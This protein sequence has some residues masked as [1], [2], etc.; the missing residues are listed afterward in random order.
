MINYLNLNLEQFDALGKKYTVL[1]CNII[2]KVF[3]ALNEPLIYAQ[4]AFSIVSSSTDPEDM[5]FF[6][7][8]SKLFFE[9]LG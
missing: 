4:S 3:K 8:N 6:D 1:Q 9:K 5:H 7:P 2:I